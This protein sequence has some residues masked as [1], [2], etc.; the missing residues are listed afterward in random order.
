MKMRLLNFR[1]VTNIL[2]LALTLGAL[3]V[4]PVAAD[5]FELEGGTWTCEA[6]CWNWNA[7]NGCTDWH[8]CCSNTDGRWF[9]RPL[10]N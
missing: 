3:A 4:T 2:A 8:E 10:P 9:C 5:D 7:Q 6:S 1:L